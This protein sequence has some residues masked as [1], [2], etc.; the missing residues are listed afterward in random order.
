MLKLHRSAAWTA[1]P[2]RFRSR[3]LSTSLRAFQ[4]PFH[5][6][7]R[8]ARRAS[9]RR[10]RLAREGIHG[11]R[12]TRHGARLRSNAHPRA[13]RSIQPQWSR[14]MM[15]L[16]VLFPVPAEPA[17]VGARVRARSESRAV[18][19]SAL[20]V[21]APAGSWQARRPLALRARRGAT[22]NG[23]WEARR[24]VLST[25]ERKRQGHAVH[26]ACRGSLSMRVGSL[27]PGPPPLTQTIVDR[28]LCC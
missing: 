9:G 27:Q 21:D 24:D 23:V 22:L 5:V 13:D 20:P 16:K 18:S 14:G 1:R 19:P 25:R 4:T 6:A 12:T 8:R 7:P 3:A 10:A 11:E 17:A 28:T 15:P 26:A 2:C